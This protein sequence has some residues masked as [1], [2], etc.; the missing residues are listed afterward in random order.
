MVC[1]D[2]SKWG[3]AFDRTSHA[4]K[5]ERKQAQSSLVN[6]SKA[7]HMSFKMKNRQMENTLNVPKPENL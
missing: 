4:L 2:S 6:I 7:R 3:K 1:L 5:P